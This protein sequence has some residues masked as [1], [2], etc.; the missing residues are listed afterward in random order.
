[1]KKMSLLHTAKKQSRKRLLTGPDEVKSNK[2][3]ISP[4]ITRR[5]TDNAADTS[6]AE[7]K[8]LSKKDNLSNS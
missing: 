1:M 2:L 3:V 8:L 6:K 7:S 4:I 5:Q